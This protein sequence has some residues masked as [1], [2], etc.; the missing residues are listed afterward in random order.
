VQ[1]SDR[2]IRDVLRREAARAPIPGDM[3]RNISQRLDD[4]PNTGHRPKPRLRDSV[5]WRPAFVLAVAA[6]F[7]WFAL[8]PATG[9]TGFSAQVGTPSVVVPAGKPDQE[10][11]AIKVSRSGRRETPRYDTTT[12]P[13]AGES[14]NYG[15]YSPL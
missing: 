9:G 3:W 11:Q 10:N 5:Q 8:I 1:P 14:R 7:F 6:G 2:A 13:A 12:P 15:P 4:G